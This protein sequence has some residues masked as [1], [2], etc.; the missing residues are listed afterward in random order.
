MDGERAVWGAW[1]WGTS[2]EAMVIRI[3]VFATFEVEGNSRLL[4][5]RWSF[6]EPQTASPYEDKLRASGPRS[7]GLTSD[8]RSGLYMGEDVALKS[9]IGP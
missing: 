8:S 5:G 4:N 1:A 3:N 6:L 7:Q 2:G 9:R